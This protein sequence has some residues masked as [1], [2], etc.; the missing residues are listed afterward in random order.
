MYNVKKKRLTDMNGQHYLQNTRILFNKKL[1]YK[2][3]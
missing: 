3:L 2:K 1:E